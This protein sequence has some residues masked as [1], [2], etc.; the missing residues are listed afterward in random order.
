[1]VKSISGKHIVLFNDVYLK[2]AEMKIYKYN[3]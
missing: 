3:D 2:M 1:M